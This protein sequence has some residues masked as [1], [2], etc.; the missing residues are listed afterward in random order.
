MV[1]FGAPLDVKPHTALVGMLRATA[2][3]VAWLNAEIAEL[4]NLGNGDD[5]DRLFR[6]YG[7]ERDRLTRIAKVCLDAGVDEIEVEVS[8]KMAT[9]LAKAV[10]SALNAVEDLTPVQRRQFG[11]V[12]RLELQHAQTSAVDVP[13]GSI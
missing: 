13:D 1:K 10:E 5:P 7:E 12:L 3:H 8:Q 9:Q 11:Q 2:G 6:L 4:D